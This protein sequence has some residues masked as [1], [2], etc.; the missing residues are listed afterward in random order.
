MEG[1]KMAIVTTD[2]QRVQIVEIKKAKGELE[3]KD[4][5]AIR[6]AATRQRLIRENIELFQKKR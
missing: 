3:K 1:D 2:A 5:L 6:D 4:I